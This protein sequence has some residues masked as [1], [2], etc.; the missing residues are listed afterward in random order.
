MDYT[1]DRGSRLLGIFTSCIRRGPGR[2]R[3][4]DIVPGGTELE[5]WLRR[6]VRQTA[7]TRNNP[8]VNCTGVY[9][10]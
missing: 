7:H 6:G 9:C 2:E 5:L 3:I 8:Y 1:G 4:L 10:A